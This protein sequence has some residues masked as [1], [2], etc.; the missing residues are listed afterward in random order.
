MKHLQAL[1][2]DGLRAVHLLL[3][4]HFSS[5]SEDKT[6]WKATPDLARDAPS[7][8]LQQAANCRSACHCSHA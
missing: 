8:K 6:T 3:S 1:A 4:F 5:V 7:A 2:Q